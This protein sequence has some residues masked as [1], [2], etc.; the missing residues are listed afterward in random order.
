M[1]LSGTALRV[2]RNV[3]TK[4]P[5]DKSLTMS[6]VRQIKDW[7]EQ[8]DIDLRHYL[9]ANNKLHIDATL[10]EKIEQVLAQLNLAPISFNATGKSSS[11]QLKNGAWEN[12]NQRLQPTKNHLLIALHET[13]IQ[14]DL[15]TN[16]KFYYL[17]IDYECLDLEMFSALVVVENLDSFYSEE[18]LLS[19]QQHFLNKPILFTY[20]G[21]DK[22]AVSCSALK[23]KAL[24]HTMICIYYG[25]FDSKGVSMALTEGYTHIALPELN[26]LKH[27]A[28]EYQLNI[29]Q[30]SYNKSLEDY[31][32]RHPESPLAEYIVLI[33]KSAKGLLQQAHIVKQI[34]LSLLD[35]AK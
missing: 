30:F 31:L 14:C 23:R 32:V 35:I 5:Q 2:L 16:Q 15:L 34:P 26:T 22:A 10:I 12:K 4:M 28:N 18:A 6:G 24:Q 3:Q 11:D 9:R 20:R 13:Y 33:T 29:Q 21:H 8:Q 19:V 27:A 1:V 17:D 25:D 7:C